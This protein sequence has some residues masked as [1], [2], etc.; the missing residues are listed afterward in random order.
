MAASL[1]SFRPEN[2]HTMTELY[3]RQI[4]GLLT[5]GADLLVAETLLYPQEA[6]AVLLAAEL[7]GGA[8]PVMYS[9]TMQPDGALFSGQE[10]GPVL[11]GAGG[12]RGCGGGL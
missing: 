5:G 4:A 3:R 8:V 7:E 12:G 1:E 10:A 11:R 9:F 2:F 6:E